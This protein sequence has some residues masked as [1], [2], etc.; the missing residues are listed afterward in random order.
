MH[1][2]LK[3][4]CQKEQASMIAWNPQVNR[5]YAEEASQLATA[6]IACATARN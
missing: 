5:T 2:K 6:T 1:Q 4:Y 3:I